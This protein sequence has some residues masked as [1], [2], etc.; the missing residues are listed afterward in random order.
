MNYD[1]VFEPGTYV[2]MRSLTNAIDS[3]FIAEV[4]NK[5]IAKENLTDENGHHVLSREQYLEIVY[6][7][8]KEQKK[9]E[10][11]YQHPKKYKLIFIHIGEAF[12]TNVALDEN[13]RMDLYEYQS[14]M[15]TAI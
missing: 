7:Q 6:L 5:G 12:I 1:T 11:K 14:V 9:T 3:F 13:W 4:Q 15:A 10:V 2:G 8:K